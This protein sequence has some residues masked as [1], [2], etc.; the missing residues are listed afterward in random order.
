MEKIRIASFPTLA[1]IILTFISFVSATSSGCQLRGVIDRIFLEEDLLKHP[2]AERCFDCHKDIYREWKKSRHAVAWESED[3]IRRSKQRS[4]M[5]CLPCH[6]PRGVWGTTHLQGENNGVKNRGD[7]EKNGRM[8]KR[9]FVEEVSL[10]DVHHTDGVYCVSCHFW[11]G[12]G[13][14]EKGMVGPYDVWSPPHPSFKDE[15]ISKSE[16]C[17]VCHEK[18]FE[19]WEK[20]GSSK[21]CQECHMPDIGKKYLTQKPPVSWLHSRKMRNSHEFPSL[22]AKKEDIRVDVR[23]GKDGKTVIIVLENIGVPHNLPTADFGKPRL[24]VDVEYRGEKQSFT[25]SPHMKNPLKWKI[26]VE[27][28]LD[29]EDEVNTPDEEEKTEENA[30]IKI[31]ISRKLSWSKEPEEIGTW[32][33]VLGD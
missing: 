10:R 14:K 21:M 13:E 31:T 17:G 25:L 16:F 4:D 33:F 12:S 1:F 9:V 30:I 28:V 20:T 19:E 11:E 26:P 32:E 22:I 6:A 8:K 15:R 24:Y 23:R 5:D 7:N 18:T 29:I 2:P 27:L 3:F